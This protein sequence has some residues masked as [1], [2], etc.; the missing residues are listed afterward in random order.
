MDREKQISPLGIWARK[1]MAQQKPRNEAPITS[2]INAPKAISSLLY[3]QVKVADCRI[4]PNRIS[5]V[6]K[7]LF[8]SPYLYPHTY[9]PLNNM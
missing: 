8:L 7:A 6:S 4:A 1:L 5:S 2:P 9:T 3:T